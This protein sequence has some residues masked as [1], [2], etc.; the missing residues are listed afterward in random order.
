MAATLPPTNN[1]CYARH[2]NVNVAG[3]GNKLFSVTRQPRIRAA[4]QTPEIDWQLHCMTNELRALPDIL[5]DNR[6]TY[7]RPA[8]RSSSPHQSSSQA[9]RQAPHLI[10][11]RNMDAS[12][13]DKIT[14]FRIQ[15]RR[16][17][18]RQCFHAAYH[19]ERAEIFTFLAC[20]VPRCTAR[21]GWVSTLRKIKT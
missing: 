11:Q 19:L 12:D 8:E 9:P 18:Q 10:L 6:R 16:S 1:T 3:I 15:R 5:P 4:L 7:A 20:F 21:G 13:C 17:R 14:L 2:T